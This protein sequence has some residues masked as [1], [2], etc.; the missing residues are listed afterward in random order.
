M[1]ID[2]VNKRRSV[3]GRYSTLEV[4]VPTEPPT[5]PDT[6]Y[7][8]EHSDALAKL[9]AKGIPVLIVRIVEGVQDPLTEQFATPTETTIAGYAAEIPGE[10]E[11]YEQFELSPIQTKVLFF[12]PTY[13]GETPELGDTILWKS[14]TRTIGG[15]IPIQPD[16][17]LIAAKLLVT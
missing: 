15:I 11:M 5:V 3:L 9:R 1:A 17:A 8:S 4:A 10:P 6:K 7:A 14:V 12:V 16:S 2:T 13:L